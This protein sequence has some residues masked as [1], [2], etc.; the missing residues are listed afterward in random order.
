MELDGVPAIDLRQPDGNLLPLGYVPEAHPN[1]I[2]LDGQLASPPVDQPM[3][4]YPSNVKS[5]GARGCA[6]VRSPP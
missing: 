3:F 4:R 1:V 6:A 5:Y 2:R